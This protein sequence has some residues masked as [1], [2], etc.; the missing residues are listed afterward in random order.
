MEWV[1][2]DEA[3]ALAYAGAREDG[4][5][6]IAVQALEIWDE[7]PQ[8]YATEHGVRVDPAFV[9][10]QRNRAEGRL[11]LLKVWNPK[12]WGD[13]I[14]LAHSGAMTVTIAADVAKV[15]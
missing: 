9:Q 11:K 6:V 1:R 12:R 8:T 14:D 7:P 5:D 13:K 10:H 3:L 4:E 2:A 15:G